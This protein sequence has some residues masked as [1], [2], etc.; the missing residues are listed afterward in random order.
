MKNSQ[1]RQLVMILVAVLALGAGATMLLSSTSGLKGSFYSKENPALNKSYKESQGPALST[2]FMGDKGSDTSAPAQISFTFPANSSNLDLAKVRT[3]GLSFT[4][5]DP[6]IK[7]HSKDVNGKFFTNYSWELKDATGKSVWST[8]WAYDA[9]KITLPPSCITEFVGLTGKYMTCPN[10]TIPGTVF[11]NLNTGNYS[12]IGTVGDGQSGTSTTVTFTINGTTTNATGTLPQPTAAEPS[13]S[14]SHQAIIN[15]FKTGLVWEP[16]DFH[17]SKWVKDNTCMY[18]VGPMKATLCTPMTQQD[19]ITGDFSFIYKIHLTD[20]AKTALAYANDDNFY[21]K[22]AYKPYW[23][24]KAGQLVQSDIVNFKIIPGAK[25]IVVNN[26]GTDMKNNDVFFDGTDIYVKVTV[27]WPGL[28]IA[29]ELANGKGDN[30]GKYDV[31]MYFFDSLGTT[32]TAKQ[33]EVA[34]KYR[35]EQIERPNLYLQ[36][37]SSGCA[38]WGDW[39]YQIVN[40][41]GALPVNAYDKVVLYV[42]GDGYGPTKIS[43]AF[44]D[45]TPIIKGHGASSDWEC[46]DSGNGKA[47]LVRE[48]I[49]GD[50]TIFSKQGASK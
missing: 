49:K 16:T 42:S 9:S 29:S 17:K 15:T 21:F 23:G 10:G 18:N 3:N 6:N 41:G 20:E 19:R 48:T 27:P 1:N 33:I 46:H 5:T 14:T 38:G 36:V 26:G 25:F 8:G 12:L 31:D 30:W 28:A 37:T 35:T 32:N 50:T 2:S 47:Y 45:A 44:G 7:S 24:P 22:Y 4:A 13:T 39:D 34:S 40:S 43:S 11:D